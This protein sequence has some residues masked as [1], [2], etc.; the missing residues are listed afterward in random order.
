VTT[1]IAATAG[2][3]LW[4]QEAPAVMAPE[5]RFEIA[6]ARPP[7]GPI[8]VAISPDGSKVVY[9]AVT[10]GE[11]RLWLRS[12]DSVSARSLAGTENAIAPFWSADSRS[13]AF[14]A[15]VQLKRIDLDGNAVRTLAHAS[16]GLGGTWA[17]DGT[18][19]FSPNLSS[20]LSL[21]AASGG[22]PAVVTRLSP[23]QL[24]HQQPRI[25]PGGRQYL[26]HAATNAG[27]R[28]IF[29]G[30]L[31]GSGP[32]HLLDADDAAYH[33][34]SGRLLFLREGTLFSQPFD[35]LRLELTGVPSPLADRVAAFAVS[36]AGP[37]VYRAISA[38]ARRQFVWFDRAGKELG[39]VGDP[40]DA[41]RGDL[42]LSPNGRHLAV[43][44]TDN[45]NQD[46]WLFEVARGVSMRFTTHPAHDF[47][48]H[49][50]P[51]GQTIVFDSNR[52]DVFDLY[53]K[54]VREK[55]SEERLLRAARWHGASVSDW[56]SDGRFLL[57][58]TTDPETSH[59]LWALPL[60]GERTPFPVLRSEFIEPYG[61][62]S[63]D[64]KWVAYQSDESGRAEVYVRP[65]RGAGAQIRISTTG[66][67]QMRWRQDGRE[68]TYIALDGRLMAVPLRVDGDD[69][70]VG[71]PVPLFAT[72]VGD[73][74]PRRGGYFQNYVMAPDSTRFLMNTSVE[75]QSVPPITV[76]LNWRPGRP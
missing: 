44:R 30:D 26:Y 25:L 66:G 27:M 16:M 62:L 19:L 1:T 14:F 64:G 9:T 5:S 12:L 69:L 13:V 20:S 56:S 74:V 53:V 4:R 67:A 21:L 46:I 37:I 60:Q 45:D 17:G 52:E 47:S 55:A 28:S 33:A 68:L 54:S 32:R 8:D 61:Q 3:Q 57:F 71:A 43:H 10:D 15:G 29:V 2:V 34:P 48:P 7:D 38:A 41:D 70:E 23:G 11:S 58:R 59:D 65:F 31:A 73:V 6:T 22:E 35:R 63:P 36:E 51:D 72:R 18:I 50:S 76:I 24:N 75:G 39:R 49:W 40:D 42:E